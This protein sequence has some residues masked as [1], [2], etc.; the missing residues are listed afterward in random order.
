[1]NK[2]VFYD[3]ILRD[4]A[5]EINLNKLFDKKTVSGQRLIQAFFCSCWTALETQSLIEFLKSIFDGPNSTIQ[6]QHLNQ[7]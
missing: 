1:M 5:Y 2:R 4:K 3:K 6:D 7:T